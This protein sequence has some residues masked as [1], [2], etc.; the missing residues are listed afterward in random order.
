M[1]F[2]RTIGMLTLSS[3]Q[4]SLAANES[5]FNDEWTQLDLELYEE[6]QYVLECDWNMKTEKTEKCCP[7]YQVED[8][9][10]LRRRGEPL[11][12]VWLTSWV[13]D[14]VLAGN[15]TA[16]DHTNLWNYN[17]QKEVEQQILVHKE[18]EYTDEHKRM[19]GLQRELE[20]LR[21]REDAPN[22]YETT[23]WERSRPREMTMTVVRNLWVL[24]PDPKRGKDILS[25]QDI[26]RSWNEQ[27]K[28]DREAEVSEVHRE[29]EM[30]MLNETHSVEE[31]TL[32]NE[33]VV[34]EKEEPSINLSGGEREVNSPRAYSPEICGSERSQSPES[35]ASDGEYKAPTVQ[36]Q[37]VP[38][39]QNQNTYN[40][41]QYIIDQRNHKDVFKVDDA[42][43]FFTY[44]GQDLAVLKR[45]DEYADIP[46]IS[47]AHL[48]FLQ[49]NPYDEMY[50]TLENSDILELWGSRNENGF[51]EVLV[52]SITPSE[53][54]NCSGS[55]IES[56]GRQSPEVLLDL[57][58]I[59]ETSQ[60]EHTV[61]SPCAQRSGNPQSPSSA[62]SSLTRFENLSKTNAM[63]QAVIHEENSAAE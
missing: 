34:D 37:W 26:I 1:S 24:S 42:K 49:G 11:Q 47:V 18:L 63:L 39:D 9:I 60:E 27:V 10:N 4:V 7:I 20:R 13:P 22:I 57:P 54:S 45:C 8:F 15:G 36:L 30:Q 16:S 17:Q 51:C 43:D 2:S 61:E 29:R 19:K 40:I 38:L 52:R 41:G 35:N 53:T 25:P 59:P 23:E 28:L 55:D 21:K 31:F 6:G 56:N 33:Y 32:A 46:V 48:F 44:K 5:I 12:C 62:L 3:I 14:Q 50:K 58:D